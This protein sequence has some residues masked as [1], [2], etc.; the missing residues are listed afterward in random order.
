MEKKLT[1]EELQQE[2]SF[3]DFC[4]AYSEWIANGGCGDENEEQTLCQMRDIINLIQRQKA[5]IERLTEERQSLVTKLNQTDE[6]VDYWF[7]KFKAEKDEVKRLREEKEYL[8]GCAKQFLADYQKCEIERVEL[9]KQVDELKEYA[10]DIY[11]KAIDREEDA[12]SLGF[13]KGKQ[14]AVKET[15]KEI[16]ELLEKWAWKLKNEKGG[17]GNFR[18]A[19]ETV[20]Q[21]I[22]EKYLLEVANFKLVELKK[23]E[24]K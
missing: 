20:M 24:K 18:F 9:Q 1:D 10:A 3:E 5:E 7:D 21:E 4:K 17:L 23:G 15:A 19:V 11:K 13:D 6:A 2:K 14:Q 22:K 16:F 12:Y 8:N